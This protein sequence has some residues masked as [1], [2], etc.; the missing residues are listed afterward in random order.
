MSIIRATIK[1]GG[2]G[3]ALTNKI[4]ADTSGLS[5]RTIS[6]NNR[7]LLS[8]GILTKSGNQLYLTDI[9]AQ[10]ALALDYDDSEEIGRAWRTIC[11]TNDFLKTVLGALDIKRSMKLEDFGS[12]ITKKAGAPNEPDYVRGGNALVDMFLEASLIS[13][14]ESGKVSVTPEY[15]K[16]GT[17][18]DSKQ[19]IRDDKTEVI[20]AIERMEPLPTD[21]NL[22]PK[23]M[24]IRIQIEINIDI[25]PDLSEEDVE[26]MAEYVRTINQKINE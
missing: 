6:G 25:T 24:G 11:S 20:K 17:I 26:R 5:Y 15:K 10:L 8:T 23:S 18:I 1:V 16:L 3:T 19:P 22:E 14:S 4:L 21:V 13:E 2:A 12:F 7:F 9:G